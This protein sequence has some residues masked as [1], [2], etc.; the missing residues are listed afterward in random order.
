[1]PRRRHLRWL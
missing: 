1:M